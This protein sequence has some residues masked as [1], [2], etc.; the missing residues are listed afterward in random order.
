MTCKDRLLAPTESHRLQSGM[1]ASSLNVQSR[2]HSTSTNIVTNYAPGRAPVSTE[3]VDD[4]SR[5][6]EEIL[7]T[8]EVGVGAEL[9]YLYASRLIATRLA[10]MGRNILMNNGVAHRHGT[11]DWRRFSRYSTS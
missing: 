10:G 6:E 2:G 4:R 9:P 1:R 7:T 11:V 3:F 5:P 8:G